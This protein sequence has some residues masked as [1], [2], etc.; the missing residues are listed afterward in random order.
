MFWRCWQYVEGLPGVCHY[1]AQKNDV[2]FSFLKDIACSDF[3]VNQ[4]AF[5]NS[6]E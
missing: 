6:K 3:D 4:V 5:M 2:L 1:C